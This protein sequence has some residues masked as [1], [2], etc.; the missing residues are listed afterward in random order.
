MPCFYRDGI[1]DVYTPTLTCSSCHNDDIC[2][3]CHHKYYIWGKSKLRL[4][5]YMEYGKWKNY[6]FECDNCLEK[7]KLKREIKE[8]TKN[9]YKEQCDKLK[10]ENQKYK[11]Q[12]KD[13]QNDNTRM[14]KILL[15]TYL[16]LQNHF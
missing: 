9:N 1:C 12:I 15:K 5:K 13:L 11:E 2:M 10:I 7:N 6:H 16:S 3:N 8:A 14:R 4:G